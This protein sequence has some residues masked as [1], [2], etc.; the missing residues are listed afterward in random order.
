MTS[1]LGGGISVW[2][3]KPRFAKHPATRWE[4]ILLDQSEK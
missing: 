4:E 3:A 2:I 1:W